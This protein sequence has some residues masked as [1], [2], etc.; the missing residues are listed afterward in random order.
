MTWR[1]P[2]QSFIV[3]LIALIAAVQG[4]SN[5][6]TAEQVAGILGGRHGSTDTTEVRVEAGNAVDLAYDNTALAN[7][8]VWWG[9]TSMAFVV[10]AVNGGAGRGR[11]DLHSRTGYISRMGVY[12]LN[13]SMEVGTFVSI[14]VGKPESTL[15]Y[16]DANVP[17]AYYVQLANVGG[18]LKFQVKYPSE[19]GEVTD[20]WSGTVALNTPYNLYIE[21]NIVAD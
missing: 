16:T 11:T 4:T 18:A 20:T 2:L 1:M 13:S 10:N 17:A 19:A 14:A 5:D 21:Y 6:I 8:P 7:I 15:E 12:V 3:A 9:S